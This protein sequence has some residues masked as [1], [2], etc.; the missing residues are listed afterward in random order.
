[1]NKM[2]KRKEC[3]GMG[4]RREERGRGIGAWEDSARNGGNGEINKKTER[5]EWKVGR[6]TMKEGKERLKKRK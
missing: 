3:E 6:E 2:Q 4:R 5:R 1:M